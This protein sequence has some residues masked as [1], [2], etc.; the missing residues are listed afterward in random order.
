MSTTYVIFGVYRR[1]LVLK[2]KLSDVKESF[3]C[4]NK[5]GGVPVVVAQVKNAFADLD[6][7]NTRITFIFDWISCVFAILL[8]Q[9]LANLVVVSGDS[10][11]KR[12]L[13]RSV[14]FVEKYLC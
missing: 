9:L 8:N 2:Q 4:C 13:L 1:E 7:L 12:G 5:E 11:V 14:I 6:F 3:K 10:P